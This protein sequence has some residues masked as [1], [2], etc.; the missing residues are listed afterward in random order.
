MIVAEIR[1]FR[2]VDSFLSRL[3]IT[4]DQ[5]P[6]VSRPHRSRAVS[7]GDGRAHG[8]RSLTSS[9]V[10]RHGLTRAVST[11]TEE[12]ADAP[13]Y[14]RRRQFCEQSFA[15]LFRGD[16]RGPF[17][18]NVSLTL[19]LVINLIFSLS[20][21][22]HVDAITCFCQTSSSR[23]TS[24]VDNTLRNFSLAERIQHTTL[25]KT[26]STYVYNYERYTHIHIY[27][28]YYSRVIHTYTYT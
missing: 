3:I 10:D 27:Y 5:A 6:C 9:V 24:S 15:A 20:A 25:H 16:V 23:Y 17:S 14:L 4:C 2:I 21:L 28:I 11:G 1:A 7:T 12:H 26:H 13:T 19:A 18:R 8:E 22:K